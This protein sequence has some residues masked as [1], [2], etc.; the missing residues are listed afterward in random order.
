MPL[1]WFMLRCWQ[2]YLP[3][4]SQV[5]G[6]VLSAWVNF[7]LWLMC[8]ETSWKVSLILKTWKAFPFMTLDTDTTWD[9][10]NSRSGL[11]TMSGKPRQSQRS[12]SC[13][14]SITLNQW[15]NQSDHTPS[16]KSLFCE[17]NIF[18][19]EPLL[20]DFLLLEMIQSSPLW[21]L[22]STWVEYSQI[23]CYVDPVPAKI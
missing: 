10:W 18:L 2:F 7:G 12:Q 23:P 4:F 3:L 8:W 19:T 5:I 13:S 1:P 20:A 6:L 14:L 22:Q 9:F 17:I 15:I 11:A 16:L 21:R